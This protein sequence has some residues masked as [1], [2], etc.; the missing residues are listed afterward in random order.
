VLITLV[1]SDPPTTLSRDNNFLW[2]HQVT[3]AQTNFYEYNLLNGTM[4]SIQDVISTESMRFLIQSEDEQSLF[5]G[6][7]PQPDIQFSGVVVKYNISESICP[8]SITSTKIGSTN[9]QQNVVIIASTVSVGAVI[10]VGVVVLAIFIQRM[11]IKR[12]G[13]YEHDVVIQLKDWNIQYED[14]NIGEEIGKGK[15]NIS[16][17]LNLV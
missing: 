17:L 4:N 11:R 10:I 3:F 12:K 5:T 2:F 15:V 9:I 7:V 13:I 1:T 8:S 6:I 16:Y 14:L